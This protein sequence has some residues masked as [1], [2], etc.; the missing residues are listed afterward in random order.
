MARCLIG[1]SFTTYNSK[2]VTL[3]RLNVQGS[4]DTDFNPGIGANGPVYLSSYW[5]Q[6]KSLIAGGFTTY[7]GTSRPGIAGYSHPDVHLT[8]Q[9]TTCCFYNS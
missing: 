8:R 7:D 2:A 1:G 5:G 3:A 9:S 4:L 6:I